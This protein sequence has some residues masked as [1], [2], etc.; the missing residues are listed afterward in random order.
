MSVVDIQIVV[1]AVLKT[2]VALESGVAAIVELQL[3][4]TLV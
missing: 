2:A 3:V 4:L 1:T